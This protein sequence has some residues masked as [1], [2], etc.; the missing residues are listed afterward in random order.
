M[1]AEKSQRLRHTMA[2]LLA[3]P[4]ERE[5]L[6]GIMNTRSSKEGQLVN[7]KQKGKIAATESEEGAVRYSDYLV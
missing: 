6:G 2:Y 7:G 3:A 4:G 5:E 1:K